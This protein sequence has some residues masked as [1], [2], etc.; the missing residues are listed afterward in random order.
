MT[1]NL[2]VK[3]IEAVADSKGVDPEELE[4]VLADY[5]DMDALNQLAK[6]SASTWTLRF[7]LPEHSVTVTSDGVVLVDG[8][9]EQNWLSA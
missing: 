8:H 3:I 6:R 7:E 5:I 9:P 2:T 4:I 1:Q